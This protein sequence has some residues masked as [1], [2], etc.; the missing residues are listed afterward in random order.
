[1]FQAITLRFLRAFATGAI[2]TMS[3]VLIF[4]G[5]SWGDVGTWLSALA[6]SGLIGGIAGLIQAIDK[7]FRFQE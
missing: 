6:L 3:T 7:Y 2:A 4:S 1:M 5:N